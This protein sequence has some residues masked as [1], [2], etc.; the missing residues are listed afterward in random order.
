M[1]IREHKR[2]LVEGRDDLYA[3]VELMAHHI[4]W[5]DKKELAPVNVEWRDG[6]ENILDEDTIPLRLKAPNI[7]ILGILIDADDEIDRRWQRL[8]V[9]STPFFPT[10]PANLP[11]NGLILNNDQGK[12]FGVWIMPDNRKHGMLETFLRYLIPND[13]ERLWLHAE[14]STADALNHGGTYKAVHLDKARIRT[15]LAWMDPPSERFGTALMKKIFNAH[16]PASGGF[17]KWF[18]ELYQV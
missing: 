10:M 8:R 4:D 3:V 18:C 5:S 7:E 12:C 11:E 14:K 17:V 2:L 15:W 16:A 1:I 9:L 6:H 13:Q